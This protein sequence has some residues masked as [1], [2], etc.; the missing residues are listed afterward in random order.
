[1]TENLLVMFFILSTYFFI[2]FIRDDENFIP[3][4]LSGFFGFCATLSRYDG[5]FL[6]AAEAGILFLYVLLKKHMR[7][8]WMGKLILF[9]TPAFFGIFLWFM[10]DFLILGDP[11][12]FS[13]SPFSA[14]SQ[15]Q[16]W[17]GRGELLTYH[18]LSLSTLYYAVTSLRDIGILLTG[19]A[20]LGFLVYLFFQKGR[21]KFIVPLLFLVP[22]LFY[23]VTLFTGQSVIFIPD[24]TP[25]NF[26]WNLFNVRYGIMMIPFAAFFIG[27]LAAKLPKLVKPLIIIALIVQTASFATGNEKVLTYEDG[28]HGLSAEKGNNAQLWLAKNYT[29][30]YV[31]LDDYARTVSIIKS[32]IPMQDVI[33]IG[34]K[35]YWEESLK[36]PEKYADWIV[37]QKD[38]AVWKNL[39]ENPK[40]LARVYKYYKKAYT[41]PQILI[42]EKNGTQITRLPSKDELVN[43]N[44]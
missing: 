17:L 6:V 35:P 10:W 37:M 31:L 25:K 3:L 29:G 32:N 1:M 44:L 40:E 7:Q 14:K 18:N 39:Y 43:N 28:V 9:A 33:Y 21:L 8:K 26:Q 11:M 42:F 38:D 16:G 41:S 19:V 34:N 4:V 30:G 20:I 22:F 13:D 27:I 36:T 23:V 15:Q 12:Y 24:L 2:Q 5:W